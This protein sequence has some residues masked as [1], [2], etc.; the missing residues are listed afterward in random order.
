MPLK[1]FGFGVVILYYLGAY[2]YFKGGKTVEAFFNFLGGKK[3]GGFL[4]FL[5]A[6]LIKSQ[7]KL[8]IILVNHEVLL[9][10]EVF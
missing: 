9:I 8:N 7:T 6:I 2:L 4:Y 1:H 3:E 10:R 5:G